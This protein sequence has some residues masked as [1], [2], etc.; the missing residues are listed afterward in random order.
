[1][2]MATLFNFVLW[3][4]IIN[5]ALLGISFLVCAFAGDWAYR[6]HS[7][8]FPMS[9]E[10]FTVAMYSFLGAYKILFHVFNVVPLIALWIAW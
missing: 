4:T 8:W 2:D 6:L 1:M 5:G 10:A 9:R 7:R 3:C